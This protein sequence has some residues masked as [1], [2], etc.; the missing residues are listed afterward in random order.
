MTSSE[1]IVV[2]LNG[3]P[4]ENSNEILVVGTS[5]VEQT[6]NVRYPWPHW[7]GIANVWGHAGVTIDAQAE[8]ILDNY[9]GFKYIVWNLTHWHQSDPQGNG[10]YIL[11]YDWGGQDTWGKLTRD[12]WFKKFTKQPWYERTSALWIKAVIETVGNENML[13]Y[14]I[15][16]PSFINH[17]WLKDY[18][19]ISE[20]HIGD[21]RKEHGDGRGHCNQTGHQLIAVR[22]AADI[23]AKW[24]IRCKI[25][26]ETIERS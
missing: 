4:V 17:R 6:I 19:C 24:R 14:P 15:Y 20:F 18:S 3:N 21:E 1:D 26:N 7:C 16:R 10:N 2:D 9:K 25:L 13:I 22:I 5:W 11:P 12:I 8:Y 23:Y